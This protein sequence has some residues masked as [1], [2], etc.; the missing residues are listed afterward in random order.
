MNVGW[1]GESEKGG[2][3]YHQEQQQQLPTQHEREQRGQQG[4]AGEWKVHSTHTNKMP[5]EGKT[6][7]GQLGWVDKK[8]ED[9]SEEE[10]KANGMEVNDRRGKAKGRL[11]PCRHSPRSK[12]KLVTQRVGQ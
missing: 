1:G 8:L 3:R 6:G 2:G 7:M 5:E 12:R 10:E 9:S 11:I 4:E